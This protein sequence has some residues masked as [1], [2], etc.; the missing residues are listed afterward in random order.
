MNLTCTLYNDVKTKFHPFF[1][2]QDDTSDINNDIFPQ[3]SSGPEVD[4]V[5]EVTKVIL[6]FCLELCDSNQLHPILV[7]L[8]AGLIISSL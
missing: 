4:K 2:V 1:S 3:G 6:L 7:D 5:N 8:L